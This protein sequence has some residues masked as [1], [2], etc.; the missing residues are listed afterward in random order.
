MLRR[1]VRTLKKLPLDF[2]QYELRYTTKGKRIAY[3]LVGAGGGKKAL[4]VGCRDGY[5]SEK[6]KEKGYAVVSC[7]IE[8][9]YAGALRMDANRELPFA[10]NEFD[11]IW[12]AEVIEHLL[13][14]PLTI[15]EFK[16]VLKPEGIVVM[17]TPNQGFWIFRLIERLG[18]SMATIENEEHHFFFTYADMRKLLGP[19]D[20]Y[21]YFPYL[22]LKFRVV[23]TA[24]LLSPTIVLRHRN[25]KRGMPVSSAK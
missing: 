25:D 19:C 12:C 14:P 18:I 13:T 17:T 7:D 3:E 2:G 10:D 21:G 23:A 5:W 9:H 8:P 11:L 24:P 15:A 20:L 1:I 16:R 22:L 6:L 4:D